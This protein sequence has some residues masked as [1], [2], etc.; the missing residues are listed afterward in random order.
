M[1]TP[2]GTVVAGVDA[3]NVVNVVYNTEIFDI[4]LDVI[5][6]VQPVV[7]SAHHVVYISSTKAAGHCRVVFLCVI[8]VPFGSSNT[9]TNVTCSTQEGNTV[10]Q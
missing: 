6:H 1:V 5:R 3:S 7:R 10:R 4:S 2:A 8:S 9:N